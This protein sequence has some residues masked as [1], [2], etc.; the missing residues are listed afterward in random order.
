MSSS[1]LEQLKRELV[2]GDSGNYA[3]FKV[4][5]SGYTARNLLHEIE[6]LEKRSKK[7]NGPRIDLLECLLVDLSEKL[8]E[9]H[10]S[11]DG[12]YENMKYERERILSLVDNIQDVLGDG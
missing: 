1:N 8:L 3:T 9:L 7:V 6:L 4:G 5:F 11:L 10:D 2:K 12:S